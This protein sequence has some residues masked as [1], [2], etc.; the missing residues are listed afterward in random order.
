MV[1]KVSKAWEP[2]QELA[3]EY[4]SL[5]Q[6][7]YGTNPETRTERQVEIANT[8]TSK[9]QRY[10]QRLSQ[11]MYFRTSPLK[12]KGGI[13]INLRISPGTNLELNEIIQEA[14][15]GLI[16]NLHRYKP[17][18]ARITGFIQYYTTTHLYDYALKKGYLV[19]IPR[20][21]HTTVRQSYDP[22]DKESSISAIEKAITLKLSGGK[23]VLMAQLSDSQIREDFV[24]LSQ[25]VDRETEHPQSRCLDHQIKRMSRLKPVKLTDFSED[26]EEIYEDLDVSSLPQTESDPEQE[27]QGIE[28]REIV[29]KKV[30]NLSP[31]RKKALDLRFGIFSFPHLFLDFLEVGRLMGYSLRS[32]NKGPADLVSKAC[33]QLRTRSGLQP[34]VY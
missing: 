12:V 10:L 17:S 3:E 30:A 2:L 29:R 4:H 21:Q 16:E 25:L 32:Q 23:R 24:E 11:D 27:L 34:L 8:I 28:L 15:L 22:L 19:A 1:F 33:E 13:T 31:K 20:Y 5:V 7:G 9:T 26:L 18:K 14:S 6:Q